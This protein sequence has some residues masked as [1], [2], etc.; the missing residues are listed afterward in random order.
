MVISYVK[1]IFDETNSEEEDSSDI[2]AQ[3]QRYIINTEEDY[4]EN[5]SEEE[6]ENDNDDI[7]I[8]YDIVN[9]I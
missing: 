3:P 2:E 4:I 1:I 6:N 5:N 8:I 9:N 7:N